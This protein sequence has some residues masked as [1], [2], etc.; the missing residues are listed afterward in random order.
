MK[1]ILKPGGF[2]IIGTLVVASVLGVSRLLS[3]KEDLPSK[4]KGDVIGRS[5]TIVAPFSEK[6]QKPL[7]GT[8]L[9]NPQKQEWRH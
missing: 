5:S 8:S 7:R 3:P 2:A 1:I 9:I 4:V 6:K